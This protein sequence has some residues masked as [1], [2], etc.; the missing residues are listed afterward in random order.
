MSGPPWSRQSHIQAAGSSAT[1][2]S[3]SRALIQRRQQLTD[4]LRL[5]TQVIL[6]RSAPQPA[7]D[8]PAVAQPPMVVMI[9]LVRAQERTSETPSRR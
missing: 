3:L 6:S 9:S 5:G 7:A 4:E 2:S 8:D 1:G